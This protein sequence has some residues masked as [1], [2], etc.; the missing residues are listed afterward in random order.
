MN[1]GAASIVASLV[2]YG[3]SEPFNQHCAPFLNLLCLSA[4]ALRRCLTQQ[5][6]R[7]AAV[8]LLR[9][10]VTLANVAFCLLL[11]AALAQLILFGMEGSVPLTGFAW[12]VVILALVIFHY[13]T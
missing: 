1:D 6:H 11:L 5:P 9:L 13:A 4:F 3:G 10:A 7:P 8:C 12:L 2:L